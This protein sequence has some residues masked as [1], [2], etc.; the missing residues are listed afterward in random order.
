MSVGDAI[1]DGDTCCP[2]HGI[3]YSPPLEGCPKCG[4]GKYLEINFGTGPARKQE[5]KIG[6]FL[7]GDRVRRTAEARG[8]CRTAMGTLGMVRGDD[9]VHGLDYVVVDWDGDLLPSY[10]RD[11]TL[12]CLELA[13]GAASKT[14]PCPPPVHAPTAFLDAPV[15]T[16][17][18]ASALALQLARTN[19]EKAALQVAFDRLTT[20]WNAAVDT[21]ARLRDQVGRED[22]LHTE[23]VRLADELR[24]YRDELRRHDP[25]VVE[26]RERTKKR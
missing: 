26:A 25:R 6:R 18:D 1:N 8:Y 23:K 14:L 20:Q 16:A 2:T 21:T 24:F 13:D 12:A 15:Y 4:P 19:E 7:A 17:A 9:V 11:E 5:T 3:W 10:Y 22:S